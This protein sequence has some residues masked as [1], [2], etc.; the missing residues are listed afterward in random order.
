MVPDV[1]PFDH[2]TDISFPHV[3]F[4]TP[5]YVT[6]RCERPFYEWTNVDFSEPSQ[7]FSL[8]VNRSYNW[9]FRVDSETWK[10]T[11]VTQYL[12]NTSKY[13][14]RRNPSVGKTSLVFVNSS[15]CTAIAKSIHKMHVTL[16][17]VRKHIRHFAALYK[18]LCL[19]KQTQ[20]RLHSQAMSHSQGPATAVT[21]YHVTYKVQCMEPQR[22]P[23][24]SM[25]IIYVTVQLWIS[26]FWVI[27][28]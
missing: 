27:S 28:V 24:F 21:K 12:V 2:D 10:T 13:T 3:T 4:A 18:S 17:H 1:L 25:A 16:F 7:E 5:T 9:P 26:V 8:C 6:P 20:T 22:R 23:H 15:S 14:C 19:H 11:S